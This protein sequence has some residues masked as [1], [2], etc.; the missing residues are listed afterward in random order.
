[1]SLCLV[2]IYWSKR[3][4]CNLINKVEYTHTPCATTLFLRVETSCQVL[5]PAHQDYCDQL[6]SPRGPLRLCLQYL[7]APPPQTSMSARPGRGPD[8]KEE[9][10]QVNL[11]TETTRHSLFPIQIC[12][13]DSNWRAH[14]WFVT[15]TSFLCTCINLFTSW[16]SRKMEGYIIVWTSDRAGKV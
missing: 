14:S 9:D 7:W 8:E 6:N 4:S 15:W 11:R 1:M 10:G 13:W 12:V 3:R 2:R 16:G 5:T